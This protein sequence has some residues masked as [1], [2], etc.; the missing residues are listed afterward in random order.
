MIAKREVFEKIDGL[1]NEINGQVVLA[2]TSAEK[3][4]GEPNYSSVCLYVKKLLLCSIN[5][6]GVLKADGPIDV[7]GSYYYV[8]GIK[9][10]KEEG[11]VVTLSGPL[12]KSCETMIDDMP[13][14]LQVSVA[15]RIRNEV[16]RR[17][18]GPNIFQHRLSDGTDV[19]YR[20]V[21]VMGFSNRKIGLKS[22]RSVLA[23]DKMRMYI[24]EYEFNH[25]DDEL[26]AEYIENNKDEVE[27]VA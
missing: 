21:D 4:G 18:L 22:E 20:L 12:S 13:P 17:I 3:T 6:A 16:K 14:M 7:N 1:L 25:L 9:A 10:E 8:R 23:D 11:I 26:L 2:V 19:H 24:N 5:E 15:E 27:F